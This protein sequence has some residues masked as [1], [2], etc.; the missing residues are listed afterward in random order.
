MLITSDYGEIE[1][2]YDYL[3]VCNY[4][5]RKF[6]E[7]IKNTSIEKNDIT[8][9]NYFKK[10]A[11]KRINELISCNHKYNSIFLL[12]SCSLFP[13]WNLKDCWSKIELL[14][15]ESDGFEVDIDTITVQ[16]DYSDLEF[17]HDIDVINI[18][19]VQYFSLNRITSYDYKLK[20]Y[21]KSIF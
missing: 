11:D 19:E 5:N 20:F 6:F 1:I 14:L 3:K 7:Y 18:R 12:E 8:L 16:S 13:R 4:F 9:F 15:K 10:A 21:L 2:T 17:F